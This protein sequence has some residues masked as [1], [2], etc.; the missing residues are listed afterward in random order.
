MPKDKRKKGCPNKNC[1]MHANG[2]FQ[3]VENDF[4]PKCG[5]ELVFVCSK[6]FTEIED[7]GAAHRIC[8]GCEAK[9]DQK[10]EEVKDA[11][12]EV[13]GKIIAGGAALAMYA[14]HSFT[15]G[16]GKII[17]KHAEEIGK[18]A[19]EKAIKVVLRK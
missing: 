2:K 12:V 5:A 1:E 11:I 15:K 16:G 8:K 17:A 6:C 3:T 7:K 4:C 18:V 13:G 19:A 9:A 14:G 10:K